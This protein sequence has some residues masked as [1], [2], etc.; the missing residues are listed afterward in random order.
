[1]TTGYLQRLI[2]LEQVAVPVLQ[3]LCMK[4]LQGVLQSFAFY[5][6]LPVAG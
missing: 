5:A 4:M 6:P 2:C 1:M 3:L